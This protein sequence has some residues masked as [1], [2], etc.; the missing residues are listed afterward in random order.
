MRQS[1]P[2]GFLAESL[3]ST[4][5]QPKQF[6]ALL[7]VRGKTIQ[8]SS[9]LIFGAALLISDFGLFFL[10]GF[11][12]GGLRHFGQELPPLGF[13]VQ[14]GAGAALLALCAAVAFRF[15]KNGLAASAVAAAAYMLLMLPLRFLYFGGPSHPVLIAAGFAWNFLF[16]G[17]LVLSVRVVQP[18]W[19]ALAVGAAVGPLIVQ[20][21]HSFL[22][23]RIY[24][25][26]L[27]L[28]AELANAG[29]TLVSAALFAGVLWGLRDLAA[30]AAQEAAEKVTAT[31]AA[32]A[33][34]ASSPPP[35]LPSADTTIE[36]D[37]SRLPLYHTLNEFVAAVAARRAAVLRLRLAD[38]ADTYQEFVGFAGT[39]AAPRLLC[40]GCKKQFPGSFTLRLVAPE[41][42]SGA[43][44]I[45]ASAAGEQFARSLRCPGCGSAEALF[46]Y[47]TPAAE[48]ITAK[49]LD[50]LR[51]YWRHRAQQWWPAQA[52][53]TEAI[54]DSCNSSV[55]RPEGFLVGSSLYCAACCDN[56][57]GGDAL[58]RLQKNPDYFGSGELQRA[59]SFARGS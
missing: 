4:A 21:P 33:S 2:P 45:G 48:E 47:D 13:W 10:Q 30:V 11:L 8:W 23:S 39:S 17:G 58:A 20:L 46:V 54:C 26:Q 52:G 22:L 25:Y 18:L 36:I 12:Q 57:L 5:T 15:L 59:R 14:A 34:P 31:S 16:L 24:S 43:V 55:A 38:Y 40:A 6:A 42:F 27:S 29:M 28:E 7:G 56:T 44:V 9:I 1:A 35:P 49:D 41:V 19:L 50:A 3:V 53:R 37:R 32:P 51:A